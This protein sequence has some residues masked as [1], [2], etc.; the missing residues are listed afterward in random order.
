MGNRFKTRKV[1]NNFLFFKHVKNSFYFSYKFNQYK[2]LYIY[3]KLTN[4][5]VKKYQKISLIL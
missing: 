2:S 3:K 1:F 4:L 5:K